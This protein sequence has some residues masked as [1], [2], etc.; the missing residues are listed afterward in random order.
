MRLIRWII[1]LAVLSIW[2][3]LL[4]TI[5]FD[6]MYKAPDV[7]PKG[8]AIV[9]LSGGVGSDAGMGPATRQRLTKAIE[10]YTAGVAPKLLMSGGTPDPNGRPV[11]EDMKDAAVAAGV[12]AEAILVESA[13]QSTLQNALF[14][15]DMSGLDKSQP[16]ILVSQRYHL[17]RAWASFRWAGFARVSI[18]A[19]DPQKG[20][21]VSEPV[22]WEG[23]KWPLNILRAAAAS[24]AE[25]G[26]VPRENYIKYLE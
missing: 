10:L 22:L 14:A 11:A 26:N 8:Q 12:P 6:A 3:A 18:A 13:S 16:I 7:P 25:A 19:A 15:A 9:V 5:L 24:A 1:A 20:I 4:G 21:E 23:V 17:P 2:A